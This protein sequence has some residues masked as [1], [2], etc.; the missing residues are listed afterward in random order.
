MNLF[1]FYTD[2]DSGHE[3]GVFQLQTSW[4]PVEPVRFSREQ[5]D[6]YPVWI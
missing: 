5:A 4:F 2:P 3:K 6:I 1:K